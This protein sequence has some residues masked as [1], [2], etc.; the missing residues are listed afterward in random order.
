MRNKNFYS[1]IEVT[2]PGH[3][4]T[5][6][7]DKHVWIY[8]KNFKEIYGDSR[9]ETGKK[10]CLKISYGKK[11][12]YRFI[13]TTGYQGVNSKTIGLSYNSL[14]DLGIKPNTQ[15]DIQLQVEPTSAFMLMFHHPDS[16]QRVSFLTS[17]ITFILGLIIGLF[18]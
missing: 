11:S 12:I 4:L 8:A 10:N 6:D 13:E 17:I 3:M 7:Y 18:F 9:S 16:S 5:G 15:E 2:P 14:C 1:F